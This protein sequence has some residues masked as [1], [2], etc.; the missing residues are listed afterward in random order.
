MRDLRTLKAD[1]NAPG[2]AL[3]A[4][5]PGRAVEAWLDAHV[6]GSHCLLCKLADL[7][8]GRRGAVLPAERARALVQVDRVL[9][10][11]DILQSLWSK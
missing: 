3:D 5:L 9:A 6:L 11:H 1:A 10:R 7:L 4:E 2:H 8:D